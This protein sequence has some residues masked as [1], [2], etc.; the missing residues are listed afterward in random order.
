MIK[1][2]H[3]NSNL[4]HWDPADCADHQAIINNTSTIIKNGS[5]AQA[6]CTFPRNAFYIYITR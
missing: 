3:Q 2:A 1:K 5:L 6:N 4:D